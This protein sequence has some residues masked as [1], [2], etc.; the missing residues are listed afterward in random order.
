LVGLRW[1]FRDVTERKRGEEALR[2]AQAELS[3]TNANLEELVRQRTAQLEETNRRLGEE[4][5]Q[6]KLLERRLLAAVDQE[7]Q[8][9]GRELHDGLCAALTATKLQIGLLERKLGREGKV[10]AKEAQELEL[11]LNHAIE[12]AREMAHAL[13]PVP[14]ISKGLAAALAELAARIRT[15][16]GLGCVCECNPRVNVADPDT[17]QHLYRIAQEAVQNASKHGKGRRIRIKLTT[18]GGRV[19]L[20]VHND[21]AAFRPAPGLARGMGLSNMKARAELMGGTL[22]VR[23]GRVGGTVVTCTVPWPPDSADAQFNGRL[24]E[25]V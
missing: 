3:R 9:L 15:A 24:K 25:A 23:P 11:E 1:L 4:N 18:Q 21:G 6:R 17:S 7:R 22:E 8:R 20:A 5:E 12:Q 2:Q 14:E 19:V 10:N 13:N 16:T